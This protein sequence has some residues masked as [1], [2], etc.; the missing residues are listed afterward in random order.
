MVGKPDKIDENLEIDLDS[1]EYED[2]T[3]N[4][5][6]EDD[7]EEIETLEVTGPSGAVF[8]VMGIEEKT[9]YEDMARQYLEHN[10][11]VNVSDLQDLDR[12]LFFELLSYRYSH[13]VLNKKDYLGQGIVEKELH[14]AI[15]EMSMETR[16]LK[17]AL[18]MNKVSRDQD[19]GES[20]NEYWENLK[21]RAKRFGYMR[22]QQAIMAI[23][24][25][26]ELQGI[27]TLNQNS[28]EQEIRELKSS[29]GDIVDWLLEEAF[30]KFDAIDAEFRKTDQQYW[31]KEI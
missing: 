14:T 21:E 7:E 13:W 17:K 26:K 16:L 15:K 2:F 3:E 27:V 28:D 6:E 4:L 25:W 29:F 23:T 9:Y 18:G 24:L 10:K 5:I 1:V 19:R 30:P 31:I 12:V 11:F 22:N 20:I 8:T